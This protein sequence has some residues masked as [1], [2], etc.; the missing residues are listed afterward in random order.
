MGRLGIN[1]GTWLKVW[2]V[3]F[4]WPPWEV[5]E[6]LA[7]HWYIQH[8]QELVLEDISSAFISRLDDDMRR[9]AEEGGSAGRLRR[10][11]IEDPFKGFLCVDTLSSTTAQQAYHFI[12]R[13]TCRTLDHLLH[14]LSQDDAGRLDLIRK[15]YFHWSSS[16]RSEL[17]RLTRRVSFFD[18][19]LHVMHEAI[20]R[21]DRPSPV[22][23]SNRPV[24]Q[25]APA[26]NRYA[27][28]AFS[29]AAQADDSTRRYP[30][31]TGLV[32]WDRARLERVH[33]RACVAAGERVACRSSASA[34]MA[35]SRP[36]RMPTG[37]TTGRSGRT[38]VLRTG[39]V[40]RCTI[41]GTSCESAAVNS[42]TRCR[43]P[44]IDS[45][46]PST[47]SDVEG[48]LAGIQQGGTPSGE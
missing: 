37:T 26:W 21:R 45:R 20:I 32:F 14:L 3:C 35:S 6:V 11:I 16:P 12:E 15:R 41:S 25:P 5:K 34:A 46:H 18:V 33:P 30:H 42:H 8:Q 36:R 9:A 17:G 10:G 7:A 43:R 23:R 39:V 38:P 40:S 44:S 28:L 22:A 4:A 1:D 47:G 29:P 24:D 31:L 19:Y 13:S 27:G 48:G 2:C